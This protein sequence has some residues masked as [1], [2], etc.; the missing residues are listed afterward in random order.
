MVGLKPS[1]RCWAQAHRNCVLKKP[2]LIPCVSS[3]DNF[4]SSRA[5]VKSDM[6]L[7]QSLLLISPVL[8]E[9]FCLGLSWYSNLSWLNINCEIK[10]GSKSASIFTALH[11]RGMTGR[12]WRNKILIQQ[13]SSSHHLE[14]L[15]KVVP[16]KSVSRH[17]RE[18]LSA[19]LHWTG[20]RP[21]IPLK[22]LS[23]YSQCI[24]TWAIFYWSLVWSIVIPSWRWRQ[25]RSY[26]Y[27]VWQRTGQWGA[28]NPNISLLSLPTLNWL[29]IKTPSL[30]RP[31]SVCGPD[32]G[33]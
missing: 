8:L 15:N 13:I 18:A 6:C 24:S 32:W 3:S 22:W 10:G 12:R 5:L 21:T 31:G 9:S 16:C 28:R 33:D 14:W 4:N 7:S 17:D 27:C 11:S 26:Q 20:V 19:V 25:Q 2:C 1:C 23:V 30:A 29:E